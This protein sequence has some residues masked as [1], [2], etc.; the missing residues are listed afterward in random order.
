MKK[1]L[2]RLAVLPLAAFLLALPLSGCGGKDASSAPASTASEEDKPVDLDGYTF[3]FGTA[4]IDGWQFEPGASALGD[5]INE[6]FDKIQSDY[7]CTI[8]LKHYPDATLIYDQ[9]TQDILAGIKPCDILDIPL[10]IFNPLVQNKMLYRQNTIEGLDLQDENFNRS[11]VDLGTF[12]GNV[13]GSWF[14]LS[15]NVAGLFFNQ[16]LLDKEGQPNVYELFDKGEW[17]W[18]NFEAICMAMTKDLNN[19]KV[20]DK[21][22]LVGNQQIEKL[23]LFSNG[24]SIIKKD[25]GGVFGEGLT[26]PK[27][28]AAVTYLRKLALTD[29]VISPEQ[30]WQKVAGV[31]ADGDAAFLAYHVWAARTWLGDAMDDDYGFIPFPK[32]PDAE[33]YILPYMD[34]RLMV[35]PK[36]LENPTATG[37]IYSQL[38]KRLSKPWSD[39]MKQDMLDAGMDERGVEMF[40]LIT[41]KSV[42]DYSAGVPDLSIGETT[43]NAVTRAENQDPAA[44]FSSI[45]SMFDTMIQEYYGSIQ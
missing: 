12:A 6:T 19:D 29:K 40:E 32:G 10:N 3:V 15:N 30:D 28:L 23:C 31:F 11:V 35:M 5:T 27:S 34:A 13:Y 43:L 21:Y 42:A 17:T 24:G 16:K 7:N 45:K 39:S 20:P 8:E 14:G 36:S 9:V 4:W 22:G 41:E 44:Q 25:A 18:D 26:D 1:R 38:A 37:I 2:H 33:D